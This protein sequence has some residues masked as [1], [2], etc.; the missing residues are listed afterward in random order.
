M[1]E[2]FRFYRDELKL[3]VYPVDGPWSKSSIPGKKPTVGAWWDYDP[4]ECDV[5]GFFNGSNTPSDDPQW[6]AL[7]GQL[8][9]R[10]AMLASFPFPRAFAG[11]WAQALRPQCPRRCP[12]FFQEFFFGESIA[13]RPVRGQY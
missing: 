11:G 4:N 10:C 5:E 6:R 3:H 12:I 2:A 7:V 8:H 9:Y 1:A 13:G